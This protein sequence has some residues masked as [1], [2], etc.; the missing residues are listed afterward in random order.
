MQPSCIT[1]GKMTD[2]NYLVQEIKNLGYKITTARKG[3]LEILVDMKLP[4]S[5][6]E[7]REALIKKKI[8]VNKTTVYRELE[9]LKILGMTQEIVLGDN[10]RRYELTDREKHHHHLV[11]DDCGKIE[12]VNLNEEAVLSQ[13]QKQSRFQPLRHSLEFFGLC[14]DCQK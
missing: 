3:L 6:A 1:L 7:L 13:I 11:C 12:D 10:K 9:F 14:V 4:I 5:A 8:N 2:K